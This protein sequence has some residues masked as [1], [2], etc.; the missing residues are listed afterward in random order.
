MLPPLRLAG[1]EVFTIFG[2]LLLREWQEVV[3]NKI[4]D[5][6]RIRLGGRRREAQFFIDVGPVLFQKVCGKPPAKVGGIADKGVTDAAA[7]FR[8]V[9]VG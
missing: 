4:N 3:G 7:T 1:I 6:V 5:L 8:I 9:G 2:T